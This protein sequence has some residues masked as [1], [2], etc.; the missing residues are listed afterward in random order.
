MPP[1]VAGAMLAT[2]FGACGTDSTGPVPLEGAT[3]VVA[4]VEYIGN[5]AA[6]FVDSGSAQRAQMQFTGATDPIIGNSPLVPPV[7]DENF[8][9]LGPLS[10][11]PDGQ[12]L[13]FVATL[14]HD[15]SELVVVGADGSEARVASPNTQIILSRPDWSPDGTKLLY[16]MSTLSHAQG[17]ELFITYLA[18]NTVQQLTYD[19]R[20]HPLDGALRF[21]GDG[22]S[23]LYARKVGET[24]A[25][26]Y[27]A[28]SEVWRADLATGVATKLADVTGSVQ[29]IARSG[30]W[31]LVLQRKAPT[32]TGYDQRL[33]RVALTGNT[34]SATLVDSGD[35]Q[36]AHLTG[37]DARAILVR[38]TS[39]APGQTTL[40]FVTL[41]TSGGA[42]TPIRGT[43]SATIVADSYFR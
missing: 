23:I 27:E 16:A 25:P 29:A 38:N 14:A 40:E 26:L 17:V 43:R 35:L 24:T 11:S 39:T 31:A 7:R 36:R 20:Y 30:T 6:L 34:G 10:W 28:M 8:L 13:A 3:A 1:P 21:G 12:R 5:R 41:P 15:Q 32:A 42:M 4:S 19:R 33:V 9:A 37:D 22:A 18:T 2:L